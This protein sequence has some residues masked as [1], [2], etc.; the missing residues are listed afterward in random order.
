MTNQ[1][2]YLPEDTYYRG[3]RISQVWVNDHWVWKVYFGTD[4]I[5]SYL[6]KTDAHKDINVWVT[7]RST[8]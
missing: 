7:G 4:W 1:S 8:A 2:N 5:D 6:D 3:Y